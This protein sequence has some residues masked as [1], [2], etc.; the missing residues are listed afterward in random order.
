MSGMMLNFAGVS[1]A[2]VPGA[3]TIG[4]ATQT[5]ATTA[6]VAYTAPANNGGSVIT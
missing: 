5:G 6:T 3:P 2:T 1:A 4:T